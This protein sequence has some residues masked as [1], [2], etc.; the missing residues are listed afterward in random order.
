MYQRIVIVGIT[1]SGKTTLA[2][3]LAGLWQFNAIELDALYWN[4]GWK[5]SSWEVLRPNLDTLLKPDGTWIVDGNYSKIRDLTWSRAEMVVWLDYPLAVSLW[6]LLQRTLKRIIQ[7]QELWGGSRETIKGAFFSRD[8]IFLW[9]FKSY[10]QY[11]KDYPRLLASPEFEHLK[12]VRLKSPAETQRWL[13][14][15]G[16]QI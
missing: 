12:V 9:A 3:K 2:Q 11:K 15:L 6:F 8:S 14:G 4:P 13:F 5:A 16:R 7:R 10:S 1:G